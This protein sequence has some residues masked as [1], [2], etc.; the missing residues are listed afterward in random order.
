MTKF[1]IT[2]DFFSA[3]AQVKDSKVVME[4]SKLD[5][6][7]YGVFAHNGDSVAECG[8]F[9]KE[10]LRSIWQILTTER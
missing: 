4:I 3:K 5:D 10:E 9:T 7:S 6:E 2:K 1:S 8:C